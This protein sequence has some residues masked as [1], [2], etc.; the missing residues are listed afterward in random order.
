ML[1]ELLNCEIKEN[2]GIG[3]ICF[4]MSEEEFYNRYNIEYYIERGIILF[5]AF[6]N[7]IK[8]YLF[9]ESINLLFKK[10]KDSSTFLDG[11]YLSNHFRGK[12]LGNI[13]IGS[14]LGELRAFRKDI[15][16]EED[17][18]FLGSGY[19]IKI[20]VDIDQ[21]T[22]LSHGLDD[23]YTG[24]IDHC[25]ITKIMMNPWCR[26]E[27]WCNDSTALWLGGKQGDKWIEPDEN[28]LETRYQYGDEDSMQDKEP[29]LTNQEA[30]ILY[31]LLYN[32]QLSHEQ[33]ITWAYSQYHEKGCSQWIENL[34]LCGD[35]NQAKLLI[36]EK[37]SIIGLSDRVYLSKIAYEYFKHLSSIEETIKKLLKMQHFF[38]KDTIEILYRIEDIYHHQESVSVMLKDLLTPYKTL[39]QNN[40]TNFYQA[41]EMLSYS[42]NVK[43]SAVSHEDY[44]TIKD[45]RT[46]IFNNSDTIHQMIEKILNHSDFSVMKKLENAQWLIY[47]NGEKVLRL[48]VRQ[49]Y[50]DR[51]VFYEYPFALIE[52]R[53][54]VEIFCKC[55]V[56][57]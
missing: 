6:D 8:Y 20:E 7:Y 46:M 54:S 31:Y 55:N 25:P 52:Y 38:D 18:L 41:Q 26:D 2:V 36:E 17:K 29:N 5:N 33:L 47:L 16:W 13:T 24:A 19:R 32:E 23:F 15:Q 44:N 53:S 4:G 34:A 28:Y 1:E 40:I 43:R 35:I 11:I 37:F 27:Y 39:Y 57:V 48:I 10:L 3:D 9:D 30:N 56:Q 42:I 45:G 12:F 22:Y 49:D 14:S 50:I 21:K 51:E